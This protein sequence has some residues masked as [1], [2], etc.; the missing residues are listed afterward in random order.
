MELKKF[1]LDHVF[2]R[3][4][5]KRLQFLSEQLNYLLQ[6]ND[7]YT[8]YYNT[9]RIK[10]LE[11]TNLQKFLD[12]S[13]Q[14]YYIDISL[15]NVE[16]EISLEDLDLIN[17]TKLGK[18]YIDKIN[19]YNK[20]TKQLLLYN[21]HMDQYASVQKDIRYL[22]EKENITEIPNILTKFG[23][24]KKE[25][26]MCIFCKFE[27][28]DIYRMTIMD[29]IYAYLLYGEYCNNQIYKNRLVM[30]IGAFALSSRTLSS[31]ELKLIEEL[32]SE[33]RLG[34]G[35]FALKF[36]EDIIIPEINNRIE[37]Y[38]KINKDSE[39]FWRLY[40]INKI[41]GTSGSLNSDT[42]EEGRKK[43]YECNGFSFNGRKFNKCLDINTRN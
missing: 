35:T 6:Y 9:C 34:H 5:K 27:N 42:N 12:I 28:K 25:N 13:F 31:V 22:I 40:K 20:V 17:N 8:K 7:V 43:F 1:L 3:V 11:T 10:L 21:K 36:L 38:N 32:S 33:K 15:F 37:K 23:F 30:N 39:D 14:D 24:D 26:L 19:L 29:G 16:D 18:D 4:Y 2:N 41:F